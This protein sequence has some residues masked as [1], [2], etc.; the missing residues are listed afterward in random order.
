MDYEAESRRGD[1]AKAL[2]EHPLLVEAFDTIERELIEAWK[3]SPVRDAEGREKIHMSMCLLQKLK[4]QIQEAVEN[5]KVAKSMLER[6]NQKVS[7]IFKA[8]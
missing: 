6:L 8:S 2:L 5:G 3:N 4:A 7:S 1:Q